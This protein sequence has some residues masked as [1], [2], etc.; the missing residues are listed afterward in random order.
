MAWRFRATWS[1]WV[2]VHVG[3]LCPNFGWCQ[4]PSTS[5][6]GDAE[7]LR[8]ASHAIA[9]NPQ[10]PESYRT[11]AA[12]LERRS[13]F[14]QALADW[15]QALELEP[16]HAPTYNARGA[17]HFKRGNVRRSIADFD[18][19]L[20]LQPQE[21]PK[22]WMRGI[23]L[24]YAG[25]YADGQKQFEGYEQIDTNDVENAVWHF[26]CVARA[27]GIERARERLLKIGNDARVP[28]MTIYALFRG[29]AKPEDVLKAA[30][31]DKVSA[32]QRR[33]RL[34]Y[35]HLY[36]ALY[37]E[38]LGDPS[39]TSAH[40]QK[41][42]EHHVDHYMY[43]VARVHWGLLHQGP[44]DLEAL[45]EVPRAEY[46]DA[47]TG[48]Q[49][50]LYANESFQGG[51]TR[52]FA[53]LARPEKIEGKRPAMVLVHGGGG[54][55]FREWAELWAKRGY[56]ALAMD[57]A[58]MGG[59]GKKLPDGGPGQDDHAK[60]QAGND[61]KDYWTYHA[62][63]AVLRGVSLL[64]SQKD[65]DP[66]R[67]GITGISWGGYLTCIAAGLDDRLKVA[68]PVYGCGF[69]HENSVW[70]PT[71]AKMAAADRE[72]W[73]ENLEPSRYLAQAKMPML[74][75][76]GT[77][78]FAYPLDSY[79]KSYNLTPNHTLCIKVKMP[80][81]HKE[82]W[83]PPEIGWFVDQYLDSGIPFPRVGSL[84]VE[85]DDVRV[86]MEG[87]TAP[88][89]AALHY[90]TDVQSPWQKREWQT[91]TTTVDG[92][93]IHAKL[94]SGRPLVYF[95]TITDDRGATVSTPHVVSK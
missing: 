34:F 9:Q 18:R 15:N 31:A 95:L 84:T 39:Q 17:T 77:N 29:D 38:V 22:H 6:K 81:G 28:M 90:T 41:A 63:A 32:E 20:E 40:L 35:A 56:V 85:G 65:V 1:A 80:H 44:W 89:K 58:G 79:Q 78:D 59:D 76:N 57:L 87:K 25:R 72:R 67:I 83:T 86:G 94:P 75:V 10:R 14:D 37:Y 54:K 33:H 46:A 61:V 64:A 53:Y 19:F 91:V 93:R 92:M 24:Y 7:A 62:I 30:Q 23:S 2:L 16:K 48:L 68:V 73:I 74:F 43:D 12:L 13:A 27:D 21:A 42:L 47:A 70:L 5:A 26:L 60:F 50:L 49:T 66:E 55:A 52:V 3:L 8:V 71:F 69:I 82:G 51:Q 45:R 4:L 88:S 36:L 11:R